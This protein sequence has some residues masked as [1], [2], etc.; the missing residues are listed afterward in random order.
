VPTFHVG[1]QKEDLMV[2]AGPDPVTMESIDAL[3]RSLWNMGQRRVS[4]PAHADDD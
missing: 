2:P 3:T 1:E 4:Q